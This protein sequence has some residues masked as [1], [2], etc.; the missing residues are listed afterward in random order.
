[1]PF[2]DEYLPLTEFT[3]YSINQYGDILNIYDHKMAYMSIQNGIPKVWLVKNGKQY[4][5]SI[6]LLVAKTW[7]E[8]SKWNHF[9]TPI[10]LDGD[11]TNCCVDNLMWRPRW[12]A[13]RY[14][15]ER[16]KCTPNCRRQ[17]A[18]ESPETGEVFR[19][20]CECATRY[21]FLE[22]DIKYRVNT[23]QPMFPYDFHLVSF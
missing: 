16:K 6:P 22:R 17:W 18:L 10:Q 11:R 1:V 19:T 4:C 5:R 15:Q 9:D 2:E 3:N 14:H 13:I 23:P 8:R 7:L 21:G 12:F 20:Y